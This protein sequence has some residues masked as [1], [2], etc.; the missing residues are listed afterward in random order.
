MSISIFFAND[1]L[2]AVYFIFTL[3]YG[4]DVRQKAN[5][6][7]FLRWVVKQ[8][9]QLST[10]TMH[11]AQELLMNIQCSGGSR[12]SAKETSAL[13]MTSVVVGYQKLTVTN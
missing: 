4:N 8:Q 11:L 5:S 6:S 3:D 7:D 12:N 2:S 13:K 10:S 9:R 1:L